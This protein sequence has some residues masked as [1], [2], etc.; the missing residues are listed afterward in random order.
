MVNIVKK[1]LDHAK[2]LAT[3]TFQIALKRALQKEVEVTANK[4]ADK[5][6]GIASENVLEPASERD[7]KKDRN[8]EITKHITRVNTTNKFLMNTNYCKHINRIEWSIKK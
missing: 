2:Q 7:K 6:R 5:I 1:L 8:I 4:T 3:D